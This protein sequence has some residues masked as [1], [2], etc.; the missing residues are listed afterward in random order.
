MSFLD[1]SEVATQ[2][3]NLDNAEGF[4]YIETYILS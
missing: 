4:W 2:I 3:E 1:S